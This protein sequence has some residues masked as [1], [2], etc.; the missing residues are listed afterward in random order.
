[1]GGCIGG[2]RTLPATDEGCG[3]GVQI[4]GDTVLKRGVL[5]LGRRRAV[6]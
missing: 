2:A 5:A 6:V 1:M 3:V 4:R